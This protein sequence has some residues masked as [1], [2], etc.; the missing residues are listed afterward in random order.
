MKYKNINKKQINMYRR[1]KNKKPKLTELKRE[2]INK[3]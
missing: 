2:Y 1:M 3:N